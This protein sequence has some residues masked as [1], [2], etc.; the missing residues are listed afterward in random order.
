VS[1]DRAEVIV[2]Q[3]E[4]AFADAEAFWRRRLQAAGVGYAPARLVF[5]TG[6]T[7]TPCAGGTAVSGPFYCP[8]SGTA[9]VDLAFL[10]ALGPRLERAEELG[11]ALVAV[12]LAA[13]HVQR[14]LGVLDAAALRLLGAP[15]GR[16]AEVAAALA[17]QA[18][19]LAGVWAAAA[20]PRIGRI[21]GDLYGRLI[22]SARNIGEDLARS[23]RRAPA[24][25]APFV[26]GG[27][28]DRER[29]FAQGYSAGD[30]AACPAPAVLA[31]AG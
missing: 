20:E 14:E 1:G 17:L 6:T 27:R 19:C 30:A 21:P 2:R 4:V 10:D 22:W 29:A 3:T 23:G 7:A 31:P 16:R 15:R 8:E 18:D 28:P 12:R 26:A 9:A 25:L 24:D 11:I 13:E 5:F